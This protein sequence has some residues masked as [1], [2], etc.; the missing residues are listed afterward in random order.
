MSLFGDLEV[1]IDPWAVE[2][3][4]GFPAEADEEV[5]PEQV[6]LDVES[7]L[8]SWRA[9]QPTPA[10]SSMARCVVFVDGVQRIEARLIVTREVLIAHGAFGS[11][12][13]GSVEIE[14]GAAAY[15]QWLVKRLVILASSQSIPASVDL[16]PGVYYLPISTVGTNPQAPARMLHNEMRAEEERFARELADDGDNLVILD[17]PLTFEEAV[18]G[19]AVGLVKRIF[20]LYLPPEGMDTVRR[21]AVG[22]RTPIFAL[23]STRRFARYSWYL[24]VGSSR[25]GDSP[26]AGIVRLEVSEGVGLQRALALADGT[27]LLLPAFIS[28]RGADPRAPQNLIPI[29]ALEARLRHLMGD[30]RLIRR[31]IESLIFRQARLREV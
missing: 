16:M 29:G 20:R 1:H 23:R 19:S 26:F 5:R 30:P 12:A 27:S 22:M 13:V 9:I 15:G 14:N 28:Q 4:P 11:Y 10:S 3:G 7:P 25:S 17:G 21:L 6:L 2:Y 18:H 8:T 31:N 24:R